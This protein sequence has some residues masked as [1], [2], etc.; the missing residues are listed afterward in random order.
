MCAEVNA[1]PIIKVPL[2]TD[3]D[4]DAEAVMQAVKADTNVIFFTVSLNIPRHFVSFSSE[5]LHIN[6][7]PRQIPRTGCFN[8]VIT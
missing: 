4:L 3:F 8:D 6:C 5:Y 7:I 1:V 2:T